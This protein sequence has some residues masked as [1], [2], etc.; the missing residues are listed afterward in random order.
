VT[1]FESKLQKNGVSSTALQV[2]LSPR[3][4][5]VVRLVAAAKTNKEIG[6]ALCISSKTV[7]WHLHVLFVAIQIRGRGELMIW[8]A[9]NKERLEWHGG[10]V[11]VTA[12]AIGCPCAY[13]FA[14]A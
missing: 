3:E 7:A 2:V 5:A 14:A 6:D 11:E 4:L 10:P 1:L 13:C 8:W 9:D 12:H